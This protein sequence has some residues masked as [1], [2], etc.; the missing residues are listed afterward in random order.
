MEAKHLIQEPPLNT[1]SLLLISLGQDTGQNPPG[2]EKATAATPA[3]THTPA[4]VLSFS[5]TNHIAT[6]GEVA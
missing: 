4:L 2:H 1:S 3:E 6:S 5:H